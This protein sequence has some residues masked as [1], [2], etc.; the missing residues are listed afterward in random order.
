M[1][2]GRVTSQ[3][4]YEKTG[5]RPLMQPFHF[6][7]LVELCCCCCC[8]SKLTDSIEF[9]TKK[10]NDSKVKM[11]EYKETI[12]KKPLGIL[13]ITF[14]DKKMAEHF[15]KDYNYGFIT[16]IFY[17]LCHKK[18]LCSRCYLCKYLPKDSSISEKLKVSQWSAKYAP[19]PSNL[20]WE[21]I[22]KIGLTWWFRF[23]LINLILV[24]VMIFFTTPS[25][26]I[27]KLSESGMYFNVTAVEL[28]LPSYVGMWKFKLFI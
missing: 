10:E 17:N 21:N 13:F 27:E 11:A 2:I 16:H 23:I 14:E 22:S 4:I 26:L 6:G 8:N 24:I 5:Q 20:K 3:K 12:L 19:S 9:Y 1:T 15:L 7:S 28:M 25:I 18:N